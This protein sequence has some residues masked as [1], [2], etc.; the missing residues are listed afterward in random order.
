VQQSSDILCGTDASD[1]AH[2]II[3]RYSRLFSA[4]SSVL[5]G[6][7]RWKLQLHMMAHIHGV[8]KANLLLSSYIV[9]FCLAKHGHPAS[10]L[11]LGASSISESVA[12]SEKSYS[13]LR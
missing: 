9:S 3:M 11:D 12:G 8:I 2:S 7:A 5:R 4:T 10:I 1:S 13:G 6:L